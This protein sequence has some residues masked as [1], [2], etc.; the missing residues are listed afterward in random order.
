MH[1][2][3]LFLL[4]RMTLIRIPVD[5]EEDYAPLTYSHPQTDGT[6]KD[7]KPRRWRPEELESEEEEGED[8]AVY[9]EE[10][11]EEEEG[12][13]EEEE[14][15]TPTHQPQHYH[16]AFGEP[17]H[18]GPATSHPPQPLPPP[19][20]PPP[21]PPIVMKGFVR[22][23]VRYADEQV[24]D[25]KQVNQPSDRTST[26]ATAPN[27]ECPSAL[28]AALTASPAEGPE[29]TIVED[30]E[31]EILPTRKRRRCAQG[32]ASATAA[33]VAAA[34]AADSPTY[35]ADGIVL[36]GS[37]DEEDDD[38]AD[39]TASAPPEATATAASTT[40]ADI[41]LLLDDD[42]PSLPVFDCVICQERITSTDQATHERSTLHT[43]NAQ[44]SV[45]TR[46]IVLPESNRGVQL[47]ARLGWRDDQGLGKDGQ[48]Q[49]QPAKSILKLDRTG[50]GHTQQLPARV[51]HFPSHNAEQAARAVDGKSEAQRKVEEMERRA[52]DG[53]AVAQ[54]RS[55]KEGEEGLGSV[56]FGEVGRCETA[57][58]RERRLR[59]EKETRA[60]ITA[61]LNGE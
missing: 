1:V 55:G 34:V 47:L 32:T 58:E 16:V 54:G 40:N 18:Y 41:V 27:D 36:L 24:D 30:D 42:D 49:I 2:F 3:L 19:L 57:R 35:A 5:E 43:F 48:G 10:E 14:E 8:A 15:G 23:K 31:V 46:R 17:G 4:A 53:R 59:K 11:E 12:D 45:S 28:Y 9:E 60:R 52:R 20:P 37:D 26:T 25:E 6:M 56:T 33:A 38:A 51:T 29:V 21:R 39:L 44:K 22:G 61:D 50:L 13:E 7:A